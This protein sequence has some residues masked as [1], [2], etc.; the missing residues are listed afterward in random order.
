MHLNFPNFVA[1]NFNFFSPCGY[2]LVASLVTVLFHLLRVAAVPSG[3]HSDVSLGS[4]VAYVSN[5]SA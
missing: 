1:Y 2:Q 4:V 3:C 5:G